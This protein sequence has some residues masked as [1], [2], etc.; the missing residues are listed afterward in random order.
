MKS[1]SKVLDD[2]EEQ[3]RVQTLQFFSML[4]DPITRRVMAKLASKYSPISVNEVPTRRLDAT[5]L[6]ILS[7]L[8]K[9]EKYGLVTSQM[10]PEDDGFY[11][12]YHIND[13]GKRWVT[14]YM[15]DELSK[16]QST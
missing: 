10:K 12:E 5:E 9:L 2:M 8:C 16:F 13:D 7:R 14:G 6:Q 3:D 11:K 15:K 1:Y 4:A